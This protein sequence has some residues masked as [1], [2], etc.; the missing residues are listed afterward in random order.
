MK[1]S[2][3]GIPPVRMEMTPLMDIVFLLLV[4]FIYAMLSMAVHHGKQ[5]DLPQSS[6]ASLETQEAVSITIESDKGGL[7]ISVDGGAAF[8]GIERLKEIL[9]EKK[10]KAP[11][12]KELDLQIFAD[13]TVSY[14]SLYSVLDSVTQAGLSRISLQAT[15]Q[16]AP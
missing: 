7:R 2:R 12:G 5:L 6:S 11:Q 3:K 16:E 15:L 1:L 9:T 8:S 13:K 4:F 14:Q 10:A